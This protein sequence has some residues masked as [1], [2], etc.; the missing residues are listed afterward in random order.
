[1]KG[2]IKHRLVG[3]LMTT[4]VISIE[5]G[6]SFKDIA[7]L[8]RDH[9]VSA[10]PVVDSERRVLGIVSEHDL[11]LKEERVTLEERHLVESSRRRRERRKAGAVTAADLMTAPAITVS[12][13]TPAAAAAALMHTRGVKRLPVVDESGRLVGIVSRVDLLKLFLRGDDEIR[14]EVLRDVVVGT[15]W[16]EPDGIEISVVD[17][18]VTFRGEVPRFSD[19]QILARLTL[20]LDGVVSVVNRLGYRVD[21]SRP[22][23]VVEPVPGMFSSLLTR[24]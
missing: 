12:A 6:S 19:G 3:D 4:G 1:M 15:L 8:M 5:Q 7:A 24:D 11:L 23:P 9:R 2:P 14:K 10:L 17:G 20:G 21:D 16:L 22:A 13:Q 18:V